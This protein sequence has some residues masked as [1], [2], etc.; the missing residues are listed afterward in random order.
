MNMDAGAE[1]GSAAKQPTLALAHPSGGQLIVSRDIDEWVQRAADL[2][3]TL[4]QS[5]AQGVDGRFTVA[6]SGGSTPKHLYSTLA[7]PAYAGQIPWER[8]HLFWGDER[9]VGPDDPESNYR[10]VRESLLDRIT[11]PEENVHRVRAE[12]SDAA[13]VARTYEADLRGFFDLQPDGLPRF[14]LILLGLGPDGHT[15]SLFPGVD[16]LRDSEHLV[17]APWV[18]K[19]NTY[20]IT[21]TAPA[22]NNAATVAFLVAGGEKARILHDVLEGPS[23]PAIFPAQLIAPANGNLLWLLDDAAAANVAH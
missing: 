6:L 1:S 18:S 22:L 4:A 21:L 19:M 16:A 12:L 13:E 9:H 2:F 17:A 11:I 23:Q 5:A 7:T 8:V 15:A 14:D 3:V 10:M 20:R